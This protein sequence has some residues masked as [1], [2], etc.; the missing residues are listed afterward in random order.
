MNSVS[1]VFKCTLVFLDDIEKKMTIIESIDLMNKIFQVFQE[2]SAKR[3]EWRF[4]KIKNIV[5]FNWKA[6]NILP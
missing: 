4:Q 6:F 1:N 2:K 5:A 3:H